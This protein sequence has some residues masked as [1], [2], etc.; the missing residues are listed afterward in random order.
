MLRQASATFFKKNGKNLPL[1]PKE[2]VPDTDLRNIKLKACD[3]LNS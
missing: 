3:F 2:P 1:D